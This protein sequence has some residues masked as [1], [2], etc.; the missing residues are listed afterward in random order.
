[1]SH[2]DGMVS[3]LTQLTRLAQR[4]PETEKWIAEALRGRLEP[5]AKTALEVAVET[6][7]PIGVVLARELVDC[8]SAAIVILVRD[9]CEEE[10][11]SSSIPL[12]EVAQ[13]ATKRSLYLLRPGV[14][15]SDEIGA[16]A[17]A[18]LANNAGIRAG[19]LGQP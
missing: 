11:Y 1:M 19:A 2:D 3:A 18:A 6:G 10:D 15:L 12:R 9:L 13:V 17:Y 14:G 7:D 5:L 16:V 4:R 8:Q